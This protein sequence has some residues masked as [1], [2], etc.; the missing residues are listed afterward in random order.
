VL[1]Q[2]AL[3]TTP[4]VSLALAAAAAVAVPWITVLT[5]QRRGA[6]PSCGAFPDALDVIVGAVRAGLPMTAALATACAEMPGPVGG[7]LRRVLDDTSIG[8]EVPAALIAAGRRVRLLEFDFFV[9]RRPGVLQREHGGNLTEMLVALGAALRRRCR[10]T[11]KNP[12]HTLGGTS[13]AMLLGA[14]PF[15]AGSALALLSPEYFSV[16]FTDP[17][18]VNLLRVATASLVVGWLAMRSIPLPGWRHDRSCCPPIPA[19]HWPLLIAVPGVLAALAVVAL[20]P[21]SGGRVHARLVALGRRESRGSRGGM[22]ETTGPGAQALLH[23]IGA[24]LAGGRLV[25]PVEMARLAAAW[26]VPACAPSRPTC[27]W[28]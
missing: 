27:C 28:R 2:T 17:R 12:R 19:L 1:A 16:L 8:V 11:R 9:L 5:V 21:H 14:M 6:R 18:G 25:G 7:E 15:L 4:Q 20:L 13:S 22:A 10:V 3:A 23:R 24:A 26:P